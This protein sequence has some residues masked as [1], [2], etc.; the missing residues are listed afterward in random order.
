M[1]LSQDEVLELI[2]YLVTSARGLLDEPADYGPMRLINAAQ[3]VCAQAAPRM[4]DAALRSALE[5][6]ADGLSRDAARRISDPAGYRRALDEHCR[7][8]AA[9]LMRRAGRATGQ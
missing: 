2:A 3:R 8:V 5:Q 9:V 4:E 1:G 6:L 7:V